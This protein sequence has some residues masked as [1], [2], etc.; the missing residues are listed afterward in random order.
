MKLTVAHMA[1]RAPPHE[2]PPPPP[3]RHRSNDGYRISSG[4]AKEEYIDY[5]VRHVLMRQGVLGVKV[6]IMLPHD[7]QGKIGPKTPLS[8]VITMLHHG[9]DLGG[10][11][12]AAAL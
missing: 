5:A 4:K 2:P 10:G 9:H 3:P 6:Q 11:V 7:P 12:S 8:D 1:A